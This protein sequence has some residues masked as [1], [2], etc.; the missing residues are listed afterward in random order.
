M[1]DAG[2]E[3]LLTKWAMTRDAVRRARLLTP[4]LAALLTGYY[5]L[6]PLRAR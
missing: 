2:V 4:R 5:I 1:T 3:P 6:T